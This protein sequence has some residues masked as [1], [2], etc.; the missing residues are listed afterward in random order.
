MLDKSKFEQFSYLSSKWVVKQ[1]RQFTTLT[2]HL[3]QELLMTIQCS[4]TLRRCARESLEDEKCHSWP[5]EVANDQVKG[6]SKLLLLKLHE[7]LPKNLTSTILWSFS[8]WSKL[9]RWKSSISGCLVSWWQ[10]KKK[11]LLK[12][13]LLLLY[14]TINH[15]SISLW[16][17]MKSGFYIT[18][19]ND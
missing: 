11:I 4:G 13:H 17:E 1:Q 6:S 3:A 14:T 2:I 5:L 12:C 15:F 9:G 16:C 19:G 10:I 18:T 8:V 7:T